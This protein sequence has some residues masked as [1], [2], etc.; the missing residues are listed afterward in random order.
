[1]ERIT[2]E[3]IAEKEF[4]IANRGYNQE[5]V[6]T[7]LDLICEEMDRLNNEIQDLRQKTTIVRA[8]APVPE[9][10]PVSRE[11]ENKFREILE[12]AATVKEET[13]RKAREDA[14]AIRLK[15]ETEAGERRAAFEFVGLQHAAHAKTLD[16]RAA[17]H[18]HGAVIAHHEQRA[19]RND[20]REIQIALAKAVFGNVRLVKQ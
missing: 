16:A 18:R 10:A 8:S 4:T 20:I 17:V 12:M 15:A 7:F 19:F 9:A 2:S 3:V 6:D 13:I 5:E 14:E 11:D 1:M